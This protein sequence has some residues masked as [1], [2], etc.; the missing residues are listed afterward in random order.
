MYHTLKKQER[1]RTAENGNEKQEWNSKSQNHKNH[2]QNEPKINKQKINRYVVLSTKK[3]K[4]WGPPR[5]R[6]KQQNVSG[7]TRIST[8]YIR[9]A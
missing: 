1:K 4:L 7:L 3:Q 2:K 8:V 5:Q 6:P 9:V